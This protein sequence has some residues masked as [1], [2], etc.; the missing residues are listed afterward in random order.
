MKRRLLALGV[1]VAAAA[2]LTATAFARHTM[3]PTLVGTVGPGYTIKLT[4]GGKK[5]ARLKAGSYTFVLHDRASIHAWSLDG[6]HGFAK[7]LTTVPF[8]GTKT[9]T[10]KLKAGA[11]KYYCPPHESMM[12]GHFTVVA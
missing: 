7:D 9:V 10:L 12:F 4:V 2:A 11:Y 1:V 6:P 5:V 3:T 8:I